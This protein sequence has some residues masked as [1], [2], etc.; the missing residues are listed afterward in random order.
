MKQLFFGFFGE[1][2]TDERYFETLLTEYL[3]E[4]GALRGIDIE[5]FSPMI[6]RSAKKTFLE[7]M[8]EIE[9]ENPGLS[10]FFVH[11]DADG[12][13][14]AR[15]LAEKW[16]PWLEECKE[17]CRWIPVVPV[18]M[19]ESWL[20]ADARALS[21]TFLIS[22]LEIEKITAGVNPENIADPKGKLEEIKR[23]GKQRRPSGREE[24][25]AQRT[26]FSE[27][28]KLPS[29]QAFARDVEERLDDLF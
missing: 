11:M 4:V 29:F 16:H 2:P 20:L 28:E 25:I 14:A 19:L 21:D 7:Q 12:R 17:P 27:L 18:R 5:I 8:R 15:V 13:N 6:M 24:T 23:A 3:T 10:L 1:G 26:R 22:E 9:K